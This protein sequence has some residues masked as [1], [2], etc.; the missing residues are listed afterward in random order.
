[1]F[2]PKRP[3]AMAPRNRMVSNTASIPS[4]TAGLN[5]RDSVAQMDV[6]FAVEMQNFWPTAW[7]VQIR[8]GWRVHAVMPD[9][10][11]RILSLLVYHNPDGTEKLFSCD[12]TGVIY[13]VTTRNVPPILEF[14]AASGYIQYTNFTNVFGT[15]LIATNGTIGPFRFD[16]TTWA[17]LVITND[18]VAD[19]ITLDPADLVDVLQFKRRLWFVERESTRSWYL[20]TDVIQGQV[21]LFDLGEIFPRG[22][23]LA[24]FGTWTVDTGVG[25]NDH[26]VF[27]SSEGDIA[28]FSGVDPD[29]D[30]EL[31]GIFQVAQPINRRSMEQR[32]GDLLVATREGIVSMAAVLQEQ[33]EGSARTITDLI[34]P[35]LSSLATD[36]A[37]VN[38]L[39]WQL[40]MVA[41]HEML[42][43]NVSDRNGVIQQYAMNVTTKAWTQFSN[44][45]AHCWEVME[46]E[47]FFGGDG[48]VGQFWTGAFDGTSVDD[49]VDGSFVNGTCIQSFQYFDTT[50][51]QKH[52]RM[53]RPTFRGGSP[54]SIAVSMTPDYVQFNANIADDPTLLGFSFGVWDITLWDESLWGLSVYPFSRWYNV[55][56]VGM[57]GAVAISA[58]CATVDCFWLASD[59]VMESG[60]TI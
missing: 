42:V 44:I 40:Q 7:G 29:V 54:P 28:L 41:R 38:L 25:I 30:F 33:S 46:G 34:K 5:V 24:D 18:V 51:K 6:R 10:S 47:P 22:G 49:L 23:Y 59:I 15:F 52:F 13:D 9:P 55:G 53:V 20:P 50:G 60:G 37:L 31:V 17:N 57:C 48:F 3:S 14:S 32:G 19:Q 4:P 43:Y 21:A 1:M 12:N 8:R 58:K 45:N 16:G 27:I 11:K 56:V 2:R 35:L 39:D 36:I 26:L